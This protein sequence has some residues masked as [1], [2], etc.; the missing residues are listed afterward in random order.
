M[1]LPSAIIKQYKDIIC[2]EKKKIKSIK[3]HQG[4]VFKRLKDKEK[5]MKLVN[6]L[7]IHRGPT[8]FKINIV[9][10][11]DKHPKMV[12]SSMTLGFLKNYYKDFKEICTKIQTS[13][14]R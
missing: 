8:I 4:K 6:E 13:L 14:N 3:Y 9:K 11:I 1:L 12:K 10:L 5:F 2:T 7:E